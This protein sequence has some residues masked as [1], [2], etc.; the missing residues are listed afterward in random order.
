MLVI[1]GL[2]L[3]WGW[4]IVIVMFKFEVCGVFGVVECGEMLWVGL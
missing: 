2:L 3:V 1:F 4:L